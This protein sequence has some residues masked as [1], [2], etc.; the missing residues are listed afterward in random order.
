MHLTAEAWRLITPTT[1]KN[2]FVKCGFSN[3]HVSGI[4][5]S[6]VNLS[7][8]ED[9]W[10]SLQPLGVQSEYFPTCDNALKVCES[11]VLTTC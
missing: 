9:D 8:E 2:C 6:S 11:R 7:E 5:D 10:H 3:D 1:N 4:D